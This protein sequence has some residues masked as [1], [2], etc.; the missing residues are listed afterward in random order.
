MDACIV[1]FFFRGGGME[2]LGVVHFSTGE[3]E[4][5]KERFVKVLN[6]VQGLSSQVSGRLDRERHSTI[7]S[8]NNLVLILCSCSVY[9]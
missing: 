4:E 3:Y 6:I 9:L 5:A 2:Q 7:K 1:I 8:G